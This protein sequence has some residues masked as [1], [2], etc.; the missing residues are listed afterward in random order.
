MSE[1]QT[2]PAVT[3]QMAN[4]LAEMGRKLRTIEDQIHELAG[5]NGSLTRDE[6]VAY[7]AIT[8]ATAALARPWHPSP[9][10]TRRNRNTTNARRRAGH[11]RR[12]ANRWRRRGGA[13]ID[14]LN[15]AVGVIVFGSVVFAGGWLA[16]RAAERIPFDPPTKPR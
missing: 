12:S 1:T 2:Q 10:D 6:Y 5:G 9:R 11:R 7:S 15:Q 4:D 16:A 3:H 8:D 14:A 13:V